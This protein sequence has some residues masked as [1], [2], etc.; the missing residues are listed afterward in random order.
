VE[1]V[2]ARAAEILALAARLL[3]DG[4]ELVVMESTSVI[5]GRE[6]TVRHGG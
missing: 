5:R 1:E 3:A 6:G 4:V 2:P